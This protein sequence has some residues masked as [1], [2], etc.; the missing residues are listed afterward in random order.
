MKPNQ[1]DRIMK[2]VKRTG[3]RFVILDKETDEAVVMMDLGDYEVLLNDSYRIEDLEGEEVLK[4]LNRDINRWQEQNEK[5]IEEITDSE[6]EDVPEFNSETPMDREVSSENTEV[7][8][9]SVKY[10]EPV[11]ANAESTEAEKSVFGEEDLS[12]LPEGE[13]EKFYL[14]PIE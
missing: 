13:E 1:L 2:L 4:R 9:N 10:V 3:D 6:L 7:A 12:D 5:K 14:E 8:E 11:A